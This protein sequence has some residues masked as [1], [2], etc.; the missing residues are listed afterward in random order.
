MILLL[1][2][3][4]VRSM[5]FAGLQNKQALVF[6]PPMDMTLCSPAVVPIDKYLFSFPATD[7][8]V[9][10]SLEYFDILLCTTQSANLQ[11]LPSSISSEPV[12]DT[13][14]AGESYEWNGKTY[15]KPGIYTD[16]LQNIH[17]CDSIVTLHLHVLPDPPLNFTVNGVSF[18][19]MRVRAGS[20]M[21][22]EIGR[23]HV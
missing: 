19:M 14:C 9:K 12:R 6:I 7:T 13:I 5:L 20:F 3:T 15:F 17:G 18:K 8:V 22:G 4:S 16:T 10:L 1:L 11:L 2:L 21:M 23:A